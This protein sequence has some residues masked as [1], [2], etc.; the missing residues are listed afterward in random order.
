MNLKWAT[1]DENIE[2]VFSHMEK[3]S[4]YTVQDILGYPLNASSYIKLLIILI[5][6]H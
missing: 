2:C 6:P 4:V 5:K 1:N 3:Y